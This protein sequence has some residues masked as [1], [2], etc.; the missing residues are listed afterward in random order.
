MP[1]KCCVAL[2]ALASALFL[3]SAIAQAE[4][5]T[6]GSRAEWLDA[7]TLLMHT[8]GQ[9]LFLGV[10]HPAAALFEKP[11]SID[12]AA[13]EHRNY[14][15]L[16]EQSGATVHT[17]VDSLLKGTLD[18]AG[19]HLPG[20]GIDELRGFA[21]QFLVYDVS[22]LQPDDRTHQKS[23][24][25]EVLAGLHARELVWIILN[26]P[27][28]KLRRIPINTGFE[29]SYE[30]RPVMNQ[31]FLRDQ[32]ITT[33]KGVVI[34]KMNSSQ[35]A[36]ETKIITFA[37]KKLGVTP[38]HEVQGDG[39][40]EGGDFIPAGDTVFL[41]Q[42]LRTNAEAVRQLLERDV[43]GAQ[44]VVI[45]KDRWQ[46]QEQMHLDTYFNVI[47]RDLAVLVETRVSRDGK[48]SVPEMRLG[49][50]IYELKDGQYRLAEKG[51][52]FQDLVEK[53]LGMRIIPVPAADQLKYGVNFLTLSGRRILAVEGV[54][55]GYKKVLKDAGVDAT[56]IDFRNMTGGYGAAHCVTQV[57]RRE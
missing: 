36:V 14:I 50:D 25:K 29:A 4:G 28:V 43:F 5:I 56:W 35:R 26:Q 17:V 12:R 10:V 39:R 44:R 49:A 8:P 42:G 18:A 27:M 22:L 11:F 54:S 31:Y 38:L 33:P 19:N 30:L 37:L 20:P 9:E 23:Y 2:S 15:R 52:D 48:Q 53:R 6:V 46:N 51:A 45:V 55:E 16:I 32:L 1:R 34:G 41:G 21:G 24:K 57:L 13:A 7:K 40:L 3:W 47:D